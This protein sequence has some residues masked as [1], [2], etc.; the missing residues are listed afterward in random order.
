M[1]FKLPGNYQKYSIFLLAVEICSCHD[2]EVFMLSWRNVHV[3][4]K[5]FSCHIEEIFMS[6]SL[7]RRKVHV[8][9]KIYSFRVKETFSLQWR[10][11][12]HDEETVMSRWR[13]AHGAIL[14]SCCDEE[15][16]LA[17][18]IWKFHHTDY[19]IKMR[20]RHQI[21]V[22]KFISP[23]LILNILWT[24]DLWKLQKICNNIIFDFL[25]QFDLI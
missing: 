1:K 17:R 12:C 20:F 5:K 9:M 6:F 14:C 10:N 25:W 24:S 19:I 8:V 11:S 23:V 2:E 15:I 3:R 22:E 7:R 13:N 18:C 16:V 21:L 4:M